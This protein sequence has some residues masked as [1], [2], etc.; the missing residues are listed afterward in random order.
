[1][2][3]EGWKGFFFGGVGELEEREMAHEKRKNKDAAYR[4]LPK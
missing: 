3:R 1:M 2:L 4:P